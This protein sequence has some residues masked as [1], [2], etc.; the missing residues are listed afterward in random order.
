MIIASKIFKTFQGIIALLWIISYASSLDH[1]LPADTEPSHYEVNISVYLEPEFNFEGK[2]LI[3]LICK[4]ATK[5][6]QL[7][8]AELN[9]KSIKLNG[10]ENAIENKTFVEEADFLIIDLKNELKEQGP[11]TLEINFEGT[12][13]N[14]LQGLYRSSYILPNSTEKR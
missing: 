13:R 10:D 7:H 3:H 9:I 5:K 8:S 4:K 12:I 2:V 1:R 11:Y 6:I 14:D